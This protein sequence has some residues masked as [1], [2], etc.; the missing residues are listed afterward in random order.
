[1]TR[2]DRSVALVTGAS[3]GIGH[4][5]AE[6]LARA[7]FTVFGTSRRKASNGP[8]GVAMLA[9]DVTDGESVDALVSTV[10]SQA[11]GIDLLVNNAGVGLLGGAEES[12]VAQVQA[13][14]DV[15]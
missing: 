10:L 3:S 1:M 15:N 9:C 13:L 14:F 5:S 11:S 12:S 7:G 2:T 8:N 4:A 6:A